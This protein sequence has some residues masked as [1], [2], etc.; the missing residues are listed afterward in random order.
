MY[1]RER[2]NYVI[3]NTRIIF[4]KTRNLDKIVRIRR[5]NSII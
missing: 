3:R 4:T 5:E 2:I 1:I